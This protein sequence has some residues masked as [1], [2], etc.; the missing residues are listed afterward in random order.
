VW[1]ILGFARF[2]SARTRR[3]SPAADAAVRSGAL[4]AG[5][6]AAFAVIVVVGYGIEALF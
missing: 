2:L 5:W 1:F 6:L 3:P 4:V